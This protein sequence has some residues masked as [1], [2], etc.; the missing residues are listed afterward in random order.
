M[1]FQIKDFASIVAAQVNHARGVTTKIT[2]FQPGSVARTLMEAPAVEVEELYLQMFLGLRDAIPVATFKS[3]G[4]DRLPAAVARG[5]VSISKTPSPT[6]ATLV[7]AG[8]TF[9][10]TDGRIYTS[11]SSVVW[12]AGAPIVRVPVA[13]AAAGTVGNAAQGSITSSPSYGSGYTVGNSEITTGRDVET[14]SEREARFAEFVAS[15]SQG[16]VV[17]SLHKAGQARLL[18]S[19]GAALEYVTRRGVLEYPGY[20]IIYMYSSAGLPSAEILADAQSR[21]DGKRDAATGAVIDTG[22]RAAGIKIDVLAMTERAVSLSVKVGMLPGYELT[23][24]VQQQI[25]D[26]YAAALSNVQPGATLYLGDLIDDLLAAD[27]VLKIVP[28]TDENIVC[29][30]SEVL[31]AGTLTVAAL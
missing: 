18:D 28:Q 26:I 22:T 27:G 20:V 24:G 5:Y 8:T 29:A 13:Y 15:L 16:T 6:A 31:T 25:G 30:V 17:A 12:L 3:F 10:A 23:S 21:I 9:T 1:P 19:E 2:D 4:F 11:T 14:D 7:P